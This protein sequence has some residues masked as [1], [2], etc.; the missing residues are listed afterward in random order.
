MID[1]RIK[2]VEAGCINAEEIMADYRKK[3]PG[4][5][6]K[7]IGSC[8]EQKCNSHILRSNYTRR[9]NGNRRQISH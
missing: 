1:D 2:L 4:V 3:L 5:T 9:R 6:G 8:R 7:I